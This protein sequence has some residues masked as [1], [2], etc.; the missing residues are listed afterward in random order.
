VKKL[1]ILPLFLLSGCAVHVEPVTPKFPEA[2]A[3]LQEKCAD[4][5]EVAEGASL[6]EFTKIVVENYILYHECSRKVE[7]WNEWYT[8]QKAI[9]EE[10][11]KK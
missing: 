2:P 3:T 6:T 8:K 7:G 11:T 1:L 9:F 4:L 5:K 10:A